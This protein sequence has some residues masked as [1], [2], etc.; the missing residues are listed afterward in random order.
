MYSTPH[1]GTEAPS[2][3]GGQRQ[4]LD[5]KAW[6]QVISHEEE[7]NNGTKKLEN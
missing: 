6:K 5:L 3:G 1:Y 7:T 4:S 2:P